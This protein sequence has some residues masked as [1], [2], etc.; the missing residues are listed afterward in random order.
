MAEQKWS[1]EEAAHN[2]AKLSAEGKWESWVVIPAD[3]PTPE[4]QLPVGRLDAQL[5]E[6]RPS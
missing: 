2:L 6:G 5:R 1:I 4:L 3:A